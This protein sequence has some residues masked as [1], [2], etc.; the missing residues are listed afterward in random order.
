[1]INNLYLI[2]IVFIL[3]LAIGSFISCL[4]WRLHEKKTMLGRSMCPKCK[5][6]ISWYENIP[7]LSFIILKGKCSKC[8]KPIS[9]QY[10]I[11]E[12]VTGI[13]FVITLL[14]NQELGIRNYDLFFIIQLLR[15]LIFTSILIIIF[16][17][18]F[19]W[20]LILDIIT[21]PAIIFALVVNLFLGFNLL[22]LL[23]A[24]VI[25]GGFFLL[26]YVI[27]KGR[28]IGG[29]DIRLGVLMG[30]ILGYPNILVALM[31]AYIFGSII[32]IILLTFKKKQWSSEIPFG[33]FLSVATIIT[34]L[35]GE[36]ILNWYL[37]SL[38]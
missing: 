22:N 32:G 29:G 38:L 33:T 37:N 2:A 13:L 19:K 10:P 14:M 9:V 35:W 28:W 30:F 20:Y 4:V 1:M 5:K 15:D 25:G 27:S 6:Q 17:Y 36:K 11:V 23:L 18:D 12:L 31:L 26:Q 16:I 34:M 8:H 3:G 7:I 24:A 21:I